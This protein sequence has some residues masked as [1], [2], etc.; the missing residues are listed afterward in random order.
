MTSIA[1]AYRI[2]I[3][4]AHNIVSETCEIISDILNIEYLSPPTLNEWKNISTGYWENWNFPN[5]IGAMD[6][7]HIQIQAPPK[8]GTLY[9]NYKKTFSIVLMAVC[10]HEYK[11]TLVDVGAFG[12][13]CDAG[14]LS[15]SLFGRALYDRTL[16]I[17][18][19]VKKLPGCDV[20]LPY[21]VVADEAFQ[22]HKNVMR[23]YSGRCL[24]DDKS[25][26][27]Y[28][29]SRA[30]RTI[31]NAFGILAS[32]WR[33]FLRPICAHPSTADR[34]VMACILLHNF[35]MTENAK[36]PP[37]EQTYCPP[38]FIDHDNMEGMIPGTWRSETSNMRNFRPCTAHRATRE[39][40]EQRDVLTKYLLSPTGEI[41]WQYAHIQENLYA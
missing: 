1:L 23:P 21:F 27:N 8:S 26:F 2:G 22:L 38:N 35:L 6:G 32:R 12:S 17:T 29:L 24:S 36:K 28:R 34:F 37:C 7:K 15:K 41:S 33:I 39:A 31:E 3:S 14:V 19:E 40:Y 25:M 20:E 11:F 5:T 16:D 18:H 9:F 4:T 10:D 13:D 30:R